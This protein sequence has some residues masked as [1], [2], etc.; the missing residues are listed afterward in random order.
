MTDSVQSAREDLAFVKAVVED[1]G[2]L[3]EWL[4]AHLLAVG[5]IFGLNLAVVGALSLAGSPVDVSVWSWL[6]ASVI[7]APVW[8]AIHRRSDYAAMGPSARVFAAACMAV[9]LMTL[10]IITSLILATARPRHRTRRS[11]PWPG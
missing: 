5:V 9:L 10:A 2:A 4:G 8:F 7:Y 6:P 1:R 11:G 3:P